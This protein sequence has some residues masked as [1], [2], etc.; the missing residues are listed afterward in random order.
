VKVTGPNGDAS[1]SFEAVDGRLPAVAGP[2]KARNMIAVLVASFG[3]QA[4]IEA[5]GGRGSSRSTAS[6]RAMPVRQDGARRF[7]PGV[8]EIVLGEAGTGAT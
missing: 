2:V 7:P 1:F 5:S 6:R 3:K 4:R 8:N